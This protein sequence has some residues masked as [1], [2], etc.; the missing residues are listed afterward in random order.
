MVVINI[1]LT[2]IFSFF[3]PSFLPE[4]FPCEIPY[5]V[6]LEPLSGPEE[7][8]PRRSDRV[9]GRRAGWTKPFCD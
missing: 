2:V 6:A 7:A 5:L 3:L 4:N 9:S 1:A 8:L